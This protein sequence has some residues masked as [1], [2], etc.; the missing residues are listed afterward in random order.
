MQRTLR[1][2][3]CPVS[4][5]LEDDDPQRRQGKQERMIFP[6][7]GLRRR[8]NAA[9][10]ALPAPPVLAGI[11]VQYLAPVSGG[12]DTDTVVAPRHGCKIADHEQDIS[13]ILRLPEKA[14]DALLGVAD[15]VPRETFARKIKFKERGLAAVQDVQV[16]HPGLERLVGGIPEKMP[17]QALFMV[18]LAPLAELRPHE[19]ELL[20]RVGKEVAQEKPHVRELLPIITGHLRKKRSLAVHHFI[21]G[22]GEHEVLGER[23]QEAEGELVMVELPVDRVMGKVLER[24]V[25]P[26]HVPLHPEPQP[27][28]VRGPRDHG[29]GRGLLGD[30]LD[31]GIPAIDLFVQ[32]PEERDG[33]DVLLAP[34]LVGDPLAF[35]A[36]IVQIEHG[37][38][39]V[40]P[41]AV[42]VVS[43][44][45]EQ[46]AAPQ[47]GTD[48]VP[49]VV[50]DV[51]LPV[52]VKAFLRV[53]VLVEMRAVEVG[54]AVLVAREMGRHPV[55]DHA[56]A[57][58]VQTVHE[59]HEVLRAS[60]PARG[61]EV[62]RGLISP[63]PV[64]RMLHHGQ[65]LHVGESH[66]LHVIHKGT[67]DLPVSEKAV[68]PLHG[69]PPGTEVDLV[70]REGR[71]KTVCR[72]PVFHPGIVAPLVR[73]IAYDGGRPRR[74]FPAEGKGI[75]FVSAVTGMAG[76]NVILVEGP[77]PDTRDEPFPYPRSIPAHAQGMRNLVPVVELADNGHALR[78]RRPDGKERALHAVM[79]QGVGAQFVVEVEVVPFLEQ[80]DVL[81]GQ[82]SHAG[83][84]TRRFFR[85]GCCFFFR[86]FRCFSLLC[87]TDLSS[88][89][90]GAVCRSTVTPGTSFL[91][92]YNGCGK[93]VQTSTITVACRPRDR[94]SRDRVYR[95]SSSTA[96]FN[97]SRIPGIADVTRLQFGMSGVPIGSSMNALAATPIALVNAS[98]AF[99]SSCRSNISPLMAASASYFMM[100]SSAFLRYVTASDLKKPS[101]K[102]AHSEA[103]VLKI[104]LQM[105]TVIFIR[106]FS[107]SSAER[108]W[109]LC[110]YVAAMSTWHTLRGE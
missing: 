74:R 109:C 29:P 101:E 13:G 26:A 104:D 38:H 31:V 84:N 21:V 102:A 105:S 27:A 89:D 57:V 22:Q 25:H 49:A 79:D 70:D 71:S 46:G 33:L 98:T 54:K 94:T 96:F 51:G 90:E 78:L 110:S 11:A 40:D 62:A 75:A 93:S 24:V 87:H 86:L 18:P 16:L 100:V 69:P 88:R 72:M 9:E 6:V 60:V 28:H 47:K 4:F 36:G 64:E 1:T 73:K 7:H 95:L 81:V 58:P 10:I 76:D 34:V 35:L 97:I 61:R 42:S 45:P 67:G 83:N 37:R 44:E 77:G 80:V 5:F 103:R 41:D 14:H 108:A 91:T 85:R 59:F 107:G 68:V 53:R 39:T 30:G 106:P 63:G 8:F 65:E 15:A 99:A 17:V 55:E 66:V 56:D 52:R 50:E 23:V 32:P 82:E 20:T 2:A 92:V 48:L 12:R 3:S 19:Q 43:L